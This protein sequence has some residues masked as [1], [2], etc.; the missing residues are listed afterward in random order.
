[1]TPSINASPSAHAEGNLQATRRMQVTPKH[2]TRTRI[3][4][5]SAPSGGAGGSAHPRGPITWPGSLRGAFGKRPSR[6]PGRRKLSHKWARSLQR[7]KPPSSANSLVR[8][9]ASYQLRQN[10]E[11]RVA[12]S[13]LLESSCGHNGASVASRSR[14]TTR[15]RSSS[16]TALGEQASGFQSALKTAAILIITCTCPLKKKNRKSHASSTRRQSQHRSS[17]PL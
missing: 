4:V 1:M 2:A 6:A 8:S 3:A 16:H 5:P 7:N 10:R 15:R 11:S 14:C 13:Q 12:P 17:A 9:P